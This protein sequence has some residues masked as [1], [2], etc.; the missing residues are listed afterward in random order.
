[1]ISNDKKEL[2]AFE[3]IKILQKSTDYI[4]E[5]LIT[6]DKNPF[7]ASFYAG[8]TSNVK[9][10][11]ITEIYEP[12]FISFSSWLHGLNTTLGQSFL[13][14]IA[15]ILSEGYKKEFSAKRNS[16][17]KVTQIQKR[18]ISNIITELINETEKPNLYRE[19]N[20]IFNISTQ[21]DLD[22]NSFTVDVYIES[23]TNIIAIELKSVRPNSGEMGGE[24]LK[25]LLAKAGLHNMF[26]GK[27]INYYIGF[28]FDPTSNTPIG[29]NKERFLDYLVDG[30]KYFA[31][32]ELLV[33]NELW[34][35]LSGDSNTMEQILEIIN[36]IATPEFINKYNYL[37]NNSNRQND[38]E[39]Y[40]I[41][42][43]KWFLFREK[44]LLNNNAI[45]LQ[46]VRDNSR[47][48][49]IL[50]Q[51]VFKDGEYNSNRYDF[52]KQLIRN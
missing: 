23:S 27:E 37:N 13:E 14:N 16:L 15:H 46:K 25:I 4:Q 22:A 11:C 33:A 10:N 2:I 51:P 1:M 18:N 47:Y 52:L 32:D 28:P 41:L 35:F 12:D 7:Y 3:V 38:T 24:K 17:L 40:N 8:I 44:D 48:T 43:N 19:N 45:I 6:S 30:S 31:V 26:I 39:N 36:A 49:K 20:L 42:L 29:H 21:P 9:G 5:N 50:N 34:D